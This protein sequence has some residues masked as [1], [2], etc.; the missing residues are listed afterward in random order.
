MS[1]DELEPHRGGLILALGI[2]G[3]VVCG[4]IA[5]FA[6]IMGKGDLAEIDGG[7][8]DPEGRG[9][10]QAGMICGIVGTALIALG[11]LAG[12]LVIVVMLARS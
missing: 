8:M 1:T 10:T 3:L 5:P 4:F 7:R 12:T 2:L 6:W 9:L 11:I